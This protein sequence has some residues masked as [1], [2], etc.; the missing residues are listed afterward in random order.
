[1]QARI[2]LWSSLTEM[3]WTYPVRDPLTKAELME[4]ER[5]R[6]DLLEASQQLHDEDNVSDRP[7]RIVKAFFGYKSI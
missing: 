6:H 3:G 2:S 1:M 7:C 5:V 4:E